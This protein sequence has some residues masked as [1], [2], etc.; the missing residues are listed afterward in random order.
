MLLSF[1]QILTHFF[2]NKVSL[3]TVTR[4]HAFCKLKTVYLF[5]GF[6]SIDRINDTLQKFKI[7]SIKTFRSKEINTPNI[8]RYRVFAGEQIVKF[9]DD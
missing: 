7:E 8:G 3:V 5:N 9:Y 2:G 6:E 1:N 4:L